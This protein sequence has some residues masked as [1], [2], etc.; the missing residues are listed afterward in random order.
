M[1]ISA[2]RI[3]ASLALALLTSAPGVAAEDWHLSGYV[4]SYAVAQSNPDIE[5]LTGA[6]A[7]PVY[8]SQNA[9]RLMLAG[10]DFLGG[11]LEIHWEAKPIFSSQRIA[12]AG[13]GL[14]TTIASTDTRYRVGDFNPA[15]DWGDDK[16]VLLQ[17]LDRFNLQY[18]QDFGTIT[19]GRQ[20]IAFGSARFLSP[21]DILEPFL[22]STL[23]QEYR[24]GVDALRF[25]KPLG[26]FSELDMGIVLGHEWRADE[27]AAFL[28]ARTSTGGS[29][30]EAVVVLQNRWAMVGGG[31]ER[32]LGNFGFWAEAAYV[33]ALDGDDYTRASFGLDHSF[34][35]NII[36]MVEYHYSGAGESDPDDYIGLAGT[37]AFQKGGVFLAGEHYLVPA[38]T[39]IATPLLS[40]SASGFFN[41]SDESAFLRLGGEYSLSEDLYMDFGVN[42]AFGEGGRASPLPPYLTLGSEFGSV[43]TTA[44]LSLRHYF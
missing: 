22:V 6:P 25:E 3:G 10:D 36:G 9:L 34:G 37:Q 12:G 7:K 15:L 42:A 44:Y 4:K 30:L 28:R 43:P 41:L 23:D 39:W 1:K 5:G 33:H 13:P 26:D 8:Q 32:A 20:A 2:N 31:I 14:S 16:A 19:F 27:S 24:V 38:V 11:A 35:D 18:A 40:V 17:N 21:T 29:D